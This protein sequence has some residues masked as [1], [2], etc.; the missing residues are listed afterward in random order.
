MAS[1]IISTYSMF[2]SQRTSIFCAIVLCVLFFGVYIPYEERKK[3][4]KKDTSAVPKK[5]TAKQAQTSSAQKNLE[6]L[7]TLR[8]AG[9]LTEE[10]YQEK[11]RSLK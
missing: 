5:N 2:L 4:K 11:K 10:E 8:K 9:L 1:M 7:K 3:K 6:Q